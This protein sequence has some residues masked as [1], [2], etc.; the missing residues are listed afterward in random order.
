[1]L[2][3]KAE[4]T[5][6]TKASPKRRITSRQWS[7]ASETCPIAIKLPAWSSTKSRTRYIARRLLPRSVSRCSRISSDW[8][9]TTSARSPS[10]QRVQTTESSQDRVAML[11]PKSNIRS[12]SSSESRSLCCKETKAASPSDLFAKVPRVKSIFIGIPLRLQLKPGAFSC[13]LAGIR[14]EVNRR[15][16]SVAEGGR[17]QR[18]RQVA[19]L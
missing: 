5:S 15:T 3:F 6:A 13:I 4:A 10:R 16:A 17:N 8:L 1:M 19:A 18:A 9:T 12:P 14:A 11:S 2:T 7:C